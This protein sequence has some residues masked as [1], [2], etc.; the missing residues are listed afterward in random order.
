MSIAPRLVLGA[1]ALLALAACAESP[2]GPRVAASRPLFSHDES[3][4]YCPS[5]DFK[6]GSKT[7]SVT[8]KHTSDVG[9]ESFDLNGN[10]LV[11]RYTDE[12]TIGKKTFNVDETT[13]DVE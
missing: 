5:K 7:V 3:A 6:L 10:D 12:F 4:S 13:D 9:Y 11:C 2:A 8:G 1:S